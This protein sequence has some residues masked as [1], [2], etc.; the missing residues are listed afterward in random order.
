M[1]SL[2]FELLSRGK[3]ILLPVVIATSQQEAERISAPWPKAHIVESAEAL[4]Q[5][6]TRGAFSW[7]SERHNPY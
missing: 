6:L 1:S 2:V 5:I 7:W 4:D 3:L